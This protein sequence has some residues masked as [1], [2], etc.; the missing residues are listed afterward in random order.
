MIVLDASALIDVLLD[1]PAAPWV[2]DQLEG[3]AI[4]APAHRSAE[5]LCALAR[6]VR[7]EV[8]DADTAHDAIADAAGLQQ[9]LHVPTRAQLARALDLQGRVRVLDAME[10]VLAQDLDATLV[11]TDG[12]LARAGLPVEVAHPDR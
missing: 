9:E 7:A 6:L 2:L 8:I 11:T 10:V 5:V 12:R 1:R 4:S 3:V